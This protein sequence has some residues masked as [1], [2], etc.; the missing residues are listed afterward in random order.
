MYFPF[1]QDYQPPAPFV[2]IQLAVPGTNEVTDL[3]PA[4][5]DTGADGTI[6]PANYIMPL[7]LPVDDRKYLRSQWGERRVVDIYWMEVRIGD[8]KFPF[9][10]IVADDLGDE[11]VLGRNILNHLILTFNSPDLRLSVRG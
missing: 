11:I 10:E 9:V 6:V 2:T 4:F 7:Q 8:I 3:L 5:V 1:N